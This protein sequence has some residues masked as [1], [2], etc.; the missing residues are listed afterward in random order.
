MK[1]Q[2]LSIAGFIIKVQSENIAG[3]TFEEGYPP[4]FISNH[5]VKPDVIIYAYN[6]IPN[7]LLTKNDLLFEAKN[8]QQNFFSIYR[9]STSY[10]LI[11][12]DQQ[13]MNSV[14]QVA[15]LNKNLNE[16]E[17]YCNK[18]SDGKIQSPFIPTW[19]NS[20]VLFYCKIRC[21]YASC[22]RYL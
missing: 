16:W 7:D 8:Q 6:G 10:K 15:I 11:I 3:I 14:Q 21:Y 1:T 20:A 19:S 5:S 13:D 9:H 18:D 4:F 12:Y 2:F 17:V 22:F